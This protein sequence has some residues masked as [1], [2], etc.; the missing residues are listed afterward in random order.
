MDEATA[1]RGRRLAWSTAIFALATGLSRVLGLVREVVAAYYFGA[2][3]KINAFTVAFQVPNLIR[4]LVADAAL[5]SAFVPVF[6]ELL[7]KGE[8]KRA[9]RVASSLFWLML[10]G[11]GGLV[12]LLIVLAPW[13]IA[14]FGDPG[15]DKQLAIGLSRVLFPIVALLGVSG[16]IVG[17]LNSYEHFTVPALTPV[18]WNLA[19]I[20]GLVLGVPR[21]QTMDAKLYVYAVSIVIGTIIQVLLP[22]PWLRGLDGRL[23]MA[24]DW[25]DPAVRRVFVLM[26]P[27]TIGLGLINFNLVVDSIFASRLINP[28][29][30]PTAIDKA[31]RIYML[32]Q[33]MFS[34]AVAT[35]LFPSL[36]RLATRGDYD[37]FRNT[38][39][40]GLRQIAF[41]LV[42]AS[43]FTAV[44]AEPIIRLVYQRGQFEP[45]QTTVVAGALAAFAAGLTFNG[46]MLMLNRAF[47]SLQSP[48]IPTVVALGNLALN[49]VLDAAF[50]RFGVWG[51]PLSTTFVNIAGTAALLELLRRRLGGIEFGETAVAFV[52]I[53]AASAVVAVVS[54]AVWRGLDTELG[55]SL[56]AQIV[57]L[58]LAIA[59]GVVAYALACRT[60]NVHELRALLSLR[61]RGA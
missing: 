18:F 24:I 59:G 2:Q 26:V 52:K 11:L 20:A 10:L 53:V 49:A 42:P 12:A 8:R 39:G 45:S 4:A 3:G 16:V 41:L 61:R 34:V 43:V 13:V 31:F 47:F 21:A 44:L 50:Y 27:V 19:I 22:V 54:Y 9:W 14:P 5:S 58:G 7:E 15:G 35:V 60:L 17:I 30:A 40:M 51:I 38:V 36:S 6:S 28:D 37:G 23:H 25:R 57:S 1:A 46:T 32:P 56:A 29:L 48:W 55:R 33:G